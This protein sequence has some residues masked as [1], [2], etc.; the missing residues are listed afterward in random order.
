MRHLSLEDNLISTFEEESLAPLK[1]ERTYVGLY[2]EEQPNKRR[3]QKEN[4]KKWW[5]Y[6]SNEQ[7]QFAFRRRAANGFSLSNFQ[8]RNYAP[9]TQ[10]TGNLCR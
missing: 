8:P 6:E 2:G 7:E 4:Q 10:R 9:V 3:E 5:F 1:R